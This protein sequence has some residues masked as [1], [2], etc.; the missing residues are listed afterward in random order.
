[1]SIFEIIEI[2]WTGGPAMK[3]SDLIALLSAIISFIALIVTLVFAALN[4]RYTRQQIQLLTDQIKDQRDQF[5][6]T[7]TPDVKVEVWTR[8]KEPRGAFLRA[9]NNHPTIP[10][11]DF[12]I[13]IEGV[14][15]S[16]KPYFFK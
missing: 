2:I 1:M 15:P 5:E 13:I 4:R 9:T 11:G 12:D 7:N 10:V 14:S 8:G 16:Q 3:T 6:V